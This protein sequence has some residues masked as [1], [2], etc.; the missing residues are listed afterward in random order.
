MKFQGFA[1]EAG[2]KIS[3]VLGI[4]T[5][6]LVDRVQIQ[7]QREMDGRSLPLVY[8]SA[9][10]LSPLLFKKRHVR[11]VL[12]AIAFSHFVEGTPRSDLKNSF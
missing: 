11:N 7:V 10:F 1:N 4:Y 2:R 5:L 8:K 3:L 12:L 6:P 9:M